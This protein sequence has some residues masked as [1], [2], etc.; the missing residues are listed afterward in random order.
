[1]NKRIKKKKEKDIIEICKTIKWEYMHQIYSTYWEANST[2]KKYEIKDADAL[3]DYKEEI[4]AK[5]M[6]Q[7]IVKRCISE[8]FPIQNYSIFEIPYGDR[9]G[10]IMEFVNT[11]EYEDYHKN[12]NKN[13]KIHEID[14][15]VTFNGY[16]IP[17]MIDNNG[18]QCNAKTCIEAVYS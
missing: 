7:R 1:M 9:N 13:I 5:E 17:Q 2:I 10:W 14:F 12:N 3:Y 16:A 11:K 18:Y 15:W 6:L 4:L 8:H